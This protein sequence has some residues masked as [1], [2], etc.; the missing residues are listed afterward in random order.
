MVKTCSG[1]NK[2]NKKLDL[3]NSSNN[4]KFEVKKDTYKT[5]ISF[6]LGKVHEKMS[7][8]VVIDNVFN[9]DLLRS[10]KNKT[11][12]EKQ[13]M[14]EIVDAIKIL[15]LQVETENYLNPINISLNINNVI[16]QLT[17]Y[18]KYRYRFVLESFLF[19]S[20]FE[21]ETDV[22]FLTCNGLSNA[23]EAL[24][25][26]KIEKVLGVTK[27]SEIVNWGLAKE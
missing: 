25:N 11:I 21:N 18:N 24:I 5:S 3:I 22:I 16:Q 10:K 19:S 23:K 26:S 9:F 27:I 15:G 8:T 4:L 1:E 6:E 17:K 7:Y 14:L 12:G 20:N 13:E 2:N